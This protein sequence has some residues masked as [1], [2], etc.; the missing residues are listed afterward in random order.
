MKPCSCAHACPTK[1]GLVNRIHSPTNSEPE[2][3]HSTGQR[4]VEMPT[5]SEMISPTENSHFGAVRMNVPCAGED[6]HD[7]SDDDHREDDIVVT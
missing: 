7:I 4:L 5:R 3:C 1:D 2:H 6:S